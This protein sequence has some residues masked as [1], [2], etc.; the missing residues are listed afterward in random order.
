MLEY[1]IF[2]P[3]STLWFGFACTKLIADFK[4]INQIMRAEGDLK[5]LGINEASK[6][7][8]NDPTCANRTKYHILGRCNKK[9]RKRSGEQPS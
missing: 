9:Q 1:T 2:A 5:A 3:I 8:Q 4:F 7:A 6:E